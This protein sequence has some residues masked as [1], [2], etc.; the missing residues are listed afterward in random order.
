MGIKAFLFDLDGTL[1]DSERLWVEAAEV[2]LR[3]KGHAL[4]HDE[5]VQLIYGRAWSDIYCEM[6]E[7]FPGAFTSIEDASERMGAEMGRLKSRCDVRIHSSI[8]LLRKLAAEYP[9]VIVSGSTRRYIED[10]MRHGG[11]EDA[12]SFYLGCEDYPRGK[13]DPAPYAE[14]ARRLGLPPAECLVFEDS[15]AGVLS[16]KAAGMRVIA[17]ARPAAPPQDLSAADQVLPDLADFRLER[18]LENP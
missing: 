2:V 16:A 6:E 3:H 14:A 9:V 5:A 12:V 18:L 10:S 7:R 15:Q 4:T 11:F 13:P 17:L 8:E 1:M